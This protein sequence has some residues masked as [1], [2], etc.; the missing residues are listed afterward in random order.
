MERLNGPNKQFGDW[1]LTGGKV[2]RCTAEQSGTSHACKKREERGEERMR[3][4]AGDRGG[5][6]TQR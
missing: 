5:R 2:I 3:V 1:K 4:Q 6:R